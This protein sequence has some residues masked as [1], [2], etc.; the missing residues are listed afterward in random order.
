MVSEVRSDHRDLAITP[1]PDEAMANISIVVD[2][3]HVRYRVFEERQLSAAELFRR[4]FRSRLA[5][6]VHAL[7]GV[8]LTIGVG[9][10]VGL[11]G[12]NGSGKST[13]L[14]C[15]AGVQKIASGRVLT[16]GRAQL[17]AVNA[18]LDPQLS[19][20]R[21]IILG[22]LAMGMT[23]QE[24]DDQL[25]SVIDFSGLNDAIQ[26]PMQTYS[27]GM[28]ARLSFSIAT[29]LKPPILLI[30][31]AL[32]VGDRRFRSKSLRRVR[33]LREDAS[34]VVM[35]TH[36]LGEIRKTCSR[37]IGL[38]DGQVVMDGETNS[39]LAAYRESQSDGDDGS[40]DDQD[41]D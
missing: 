21:N 37:T 25:A 11:V 5:S 35:V 20:R 9:E 27:S 1:E 15:M 23:S 3:V 26:R 19:G 41:D 29:M 13:L 31:E 8:S 17:L 22:G 32:A 40:D 16:R 7:R 28:R 38:E 34:T 39:I 14:R 18:A 6:E 12:P 10:S 36:N 24:I 2:D 33:D 30:D 4:G